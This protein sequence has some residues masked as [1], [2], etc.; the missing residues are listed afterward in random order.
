MLFR[1]FSAGITALKTRPGLVGLIYGMNLVIAFILAVPI[2][3]V[4]SNTVADTGFSGDLAARFDVVLW[5]DIME[6]AGPILA[7]VRAQFL[8]MVPLYLLW[9]V[10]AG[11]GLIHALRDGGVRSF[12][13]GVGRYTGPGLLLALMYLLPLL[14]WFVFTAIVGVLLN[15]LWPGEVG[16][17]W[18][19]FVII[20][21]LVITG[22]AVFDLIQDYGRTALVV[23]GK[24]VTSAWTTGFAWPFRY[25]VS[26]WL[27]LMWFVIAALL[28]LAPTFIER[29][30][31][32]AWGVFLLQQLFLFARAAVTIGWYGS[33][34]ALY[35]HVQ[36]KEAPLIA[37][38][39]EAVTLEEPS[40]NL[41]L[42]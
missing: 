12:W 40:A 27:Y 10:A 21:T 39:T 14:G 34:V 26:S 16:A 8:W 32:A 35:E 22:I 30:I 36:W 41:G 37:E 11:V 38:E 15:F 42:A 13:Q 25:G 29:N 5:A 20:P 33:E 18:S 23:G 4:L 24:T 31:G 28:L 9:Q 17:F 3:I 6:K 19:F 7:S 1:S 2:Y